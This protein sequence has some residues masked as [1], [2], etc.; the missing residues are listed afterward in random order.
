[1]NNELAQQRIKYLV[2]HG[3]LCDDPLSAISRRV[4]V[5]IWL[6]VAAVSLSAA[7]L[8]VALTRF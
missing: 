6:G 3:G 8:A 7:Q 4:R 5:A 2:E 1:M